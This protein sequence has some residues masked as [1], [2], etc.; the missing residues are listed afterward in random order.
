MIILVLGGLVALGVGIWLGMPGD[1]RATEREIEQA[2][3][4]DRGGG[5]SK[6]VKRQF[7]AVEWLMRRGKQ[8]QVRKSRQP[9]RNPFRLSGGEE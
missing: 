1:T 7:M 5:P 4:E 3:L 6:R 2:I 9:Q 8:S